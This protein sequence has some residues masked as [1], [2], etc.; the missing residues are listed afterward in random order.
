[1]V[2]N[3]NANNIP[4]YRLHSKSIKNIMDSMILWY[5][6]KRQG[7]TNES[8]AQTPVLRDLSGNGHDATCYN[9]AWYGMSGIGG[10]NVPLNW[11]ENSINQTSKQYF[12]ATVS[13]SGITS[14][15]GLILHSVIKEFTGRKI[16]WDD[17]KN[18]SGSDFIIDADIKITGIDAN[19][20][21]GITGIGL[22]MN[23]EYWSSD[24]RVLDVTT[25]GTYHVNVTYPN[26]DASSNHHMVYFYLLV[27][28]GVTIPIG[29]LNIK[30]EILPKYPNALVSDGVDD[31]AQVLKLP[32]LTREQGYTIIA[33]R[34]YLNNAKGCL[35]SYRGITATDGPFAMELVELNRTDSFGVKTTLTSIPELITWQRK[36]SYNGTSISYT[37][38]VFDTASRCLNIFKLNPTDLN[39][40]GQIALYSLILFKRDL[41]DE[42]IEWVKTNLINY[43]PLFN[44]YSFRRA[45]SG[46]QIT[47]AVNDTLVINTT[48]EQGLWMVRG[49]INLLK[50]SFN[51]T[52]NRPMFLSIADIGTDGN[53]VNKQKKY[54]DL[55]VG[56]NTVP[57]ISDE[58]LSQYNELVICRPSYDTAGEYI[59][60]AL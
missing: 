33:K 43:Q 25:D 49:D 59:I 35:A 19:K 55:Q 1:M 54:F 36:D 20:S 7:A 40:V 60:K 14:W 24:Y 3:A 28:E 18:T 37:G 51:I 53:T 48:G 34:T 29:D 38:S 46:T 15:K 58:D 39:Y 8:M 27:E 21:K 23:P 41:T 6:I 13:M 31:Y 22:F 4:A 45:N 42:E 32:F 30:I 2:S 47:Y 26:D 52:C 17:N 50:T 57:A 44:V 12:D 5:D 10:Y 56:L 11:V 16:L 9:F